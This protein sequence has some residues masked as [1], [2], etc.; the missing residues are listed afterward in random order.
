MNILELVENCRR[1]G[2]SG[3]E[4]PDGDCAGSCCG[5]A[6]YLRKML[7]QARVDIYLEPL[8]AETLRRII[9]NIIF[10]I[11]HDRNTSFAIEITCVRISCFALY[12][13]MFAGLP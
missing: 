11:N 4:N 2:I 8:T 13:G 7:P 1:I 5:I 10:D 3:H 6:L 9:E 12:I